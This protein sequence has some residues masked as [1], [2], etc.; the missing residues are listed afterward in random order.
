MLCIQ[1]SINSWEEFRVA[2]LDFLETREDYL[3][4]SRIPEE[5]VKIMS[6]ESGQVPE[7]DLIQFCTLSFLE[8]GE[9]GIREVHWKASEFITS[10][11]V[12]H[13]LMS[14]LIKIPLSAFRK[15]GTR[16]K[17]MQSRK[18]VIV[19]LMRG[20]A[21][22][23]CPIPHYVEPRKTTVVVSR[24]FVIALLEFNSSETLSFERAFFSLARTANFQC[25]RISGISK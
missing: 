22:L 17:S 10:S 8:K 16:Y 25:V 4:V 19:S 24:S 7:L 20:F 11:K 14:S 13:L 6:F 1:N 23:G 15:I 5:Q 3:L 21:T 12:I 2:A 18:Q 9:L